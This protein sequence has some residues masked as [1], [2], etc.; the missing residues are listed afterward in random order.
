MPAPRWFFRFLYD[1]ESAALQRQHD[2]PEHARADEETAD[3]LAS[4]VA[5]PGPVAD[6]G[7]GPGPHLHALARPPPARGDNALL[8]S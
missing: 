7:C 6:L 8:F 3:A 1:R 2:Q 5:L 4:L